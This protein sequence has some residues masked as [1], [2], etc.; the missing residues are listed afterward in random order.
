MEATE[1]GLLVAMVVTLGLA[2]RL[3]VVRR[4]RERFSVVRRYGDNLRRAGANEADQ[5]SSGG[6]DESRRRSA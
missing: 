3:S 1:I 6:P 2:F 5:Q 4:F